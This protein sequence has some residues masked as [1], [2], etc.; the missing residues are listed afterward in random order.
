MWHR[1]LTLGIHPVGENRNLRSTEVEQLTR[2]FSGL[3]DLIMNSRK[4]SDTGPQPN[5]TENP[6]QAGQEDSEQQI[7][8]HPKPATQAP[9]YFRRIIE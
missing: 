4:N 2:G 8:P 5:E 3:N 9:I 7:E 1:E 6:R